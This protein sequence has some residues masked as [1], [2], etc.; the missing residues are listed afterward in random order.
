MPTAFAKRVTFLL[1]IGSIATVLYANPTQ[2][3]S[4]STVD[5]ARSFTD[6]GGYNR[7]WKGSGSPEAIL[8]RGEVILPISEGGT[9]CCGFTLAVVVKAATERGLLEDKSVAQVKKF[10]KNWFGVPDGPDRTL[11]TYAMEELGVGH[12]I[13]LAKAKPGDFVQLWRT[14]GSGH[15][16]LFLKWVTEAGKQVGFHYR[17]SQGSTDGIADKIEYFSDDPKGRG[18]VDRDDTYACRLYK[19]KEQARKVRPEK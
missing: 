13:P 1:T 10:H 5:I 19:T 3:D 11:C 4:R 8:H 9:F 2:K 7:Q 17:S 18:N 14:S 16:V 6:G 12:A 15:S